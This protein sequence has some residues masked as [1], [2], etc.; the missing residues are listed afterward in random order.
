LP[1][2]Q[3]DA[4]A[5]AVGMF[6]GSEA[7]AEMSAANRYSMLI[8]SLPY[9]GVLFG[10][11]QTP[12]SRIRLQQRLS[13]LAPAD[14]A[15]LRAAADL[16]DWS[17]LGRERHDAELIARAR[18]VI[19]TLGNVFVRDLVVWR[20][21]LRTVVAALRRRQSGQAAPPAH[22]RWGYGRWLAQLRR[23]WNEP[24]FRLERAFPWLPEARTL[25]ESGDAQA[26]ERL[27]FGTVWDYLERLADGHHF[28]FE[29]VVIYTQRWDLIARW[30]G[31]DSEAAVAR[32][33][34]LVETG[35]RTLPLDALVA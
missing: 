7:P 12:L 27:L 14:A 3:I 25:L 26:L 4:L 5:T 24:H 6:T 16:L 29:A 32:F 19:P 20:L 22:E 2:A 13:L 33:D 21:E 11:R 31:Y 8:S 18:A 1:R 15:C 28:D 34:E 23:H 17:H 30:T 35:L 9:H 10:A